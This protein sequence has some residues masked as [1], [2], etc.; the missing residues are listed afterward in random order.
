MWQHS[1]IMRRE[2]KR[3]LYCAV[4]QLLLLVG[5]HFFANCQHRSL[6]ILQTFTSFSLICKTYARCNI[7]KAFFCKFLYEYLS[8]SCCTFCSCFSFQLFL[9]CNRRGEWEAEISRG[10]PGW[11]LRGILF[12]NARYDKMTIYDMLPIKLWAKLMIF[13]TVLD[14]IETPYREYL[15]KVLLIGDPGVGKTS[16]VQRYTNNIFRYNFTWAFLHIN[17]RY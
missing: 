11:L 14:V 8:T 7:D 12:P 2:K 15:Y 5:H 13:F 10:C 17:L 3:M 1:N 6:N 16:F 4:R 9:S